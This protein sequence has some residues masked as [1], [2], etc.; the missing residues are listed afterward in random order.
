MRSVRSGYLWE[1]LFQMPARFNGSG[2]IGQSIS[3][4]RDWWSK[5]QWDNC[6]L[7]LTGGM[8]NRRVN[9]PLKLVRVPAF[10]RRR[11]AL[12]QSVVR[13]KARTNGA[14]G[15]TNY[16]DICWQLMFVVPTVCHFFSGN[17]ITS[18]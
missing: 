16:V 9:S 7:C 13:K 2:L 15:T 8:N 6:Q 18:T 3:I 11:V 14:R 5:L 1:L 4:L 10:R 12:R 17:S